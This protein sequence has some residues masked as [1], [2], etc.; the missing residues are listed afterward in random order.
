MH[1]TL[2]A[3]ADARYDTLSYYLIGANAMYDAV[4]YLALTH[5]LTFIPDYVI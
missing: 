2:L 5:Y 1:D 4:N 3:R